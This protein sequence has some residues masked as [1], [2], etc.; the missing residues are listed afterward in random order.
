MKARNKSEAIRIAKES[1]GMPYLEGTSWTYEITD[2][3]TGEVRKGLK[4]PIHYRVRAARS[5]DMIKVACKALG[6]PALVA[7]AKAGSY[8]YAASVGEARWYD[9]VP[10][11]PSSEV[12]A[13]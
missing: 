9:Y 13:P 6:F 11:Q 12:E 1:V 2:P 3:E 7:S 8:W 5:E 4:H 10:S